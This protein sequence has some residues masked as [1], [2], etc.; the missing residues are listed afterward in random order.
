LDSRSS[1][2]LIC[3]VGGTLCSLPIDSTVE[4][5]RPLPTEAIAGAPVFVLGLSIV[6]GEPMPVVDLT[7]LITGLPG[8]PSRF[9]VIKTGTRRVALAVDAVVG[10]REIAARQAA[11]LPPLIEDA[12]T[13]AIAAVGALDR[14]LFLV[15]QAARLVP[16]GVLDADLGQR[17]A[18]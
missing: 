13:S 15:L 11:G 18:S 2:S 4:T 12:G 6:R 5:F 16:E 10:V 3:R 9:V 14:E 17:R 8:R 1:R 7:R